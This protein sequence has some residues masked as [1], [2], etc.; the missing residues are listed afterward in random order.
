MIKFEQVDL[1]RMLFVQAEI[2]KTILP[3]RQNTEASLVIFA[4]VRCAK[5]L[6]DLYPPETREQ[7]AEVVIYF[8]RGGKD[9]PELVA[10]LEKFFH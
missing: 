9:N 3:Y 8:L 10:G 6:L 5:I 4:L 7:L 2:A 1:E